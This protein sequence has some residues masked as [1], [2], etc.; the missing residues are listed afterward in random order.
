VHSRTLAEAFLD[1]LPS[2]ARTEAEATPEL[3]E[4]LRQVC[5]AAAQEWPE[6]LDDD[7][8]FLA[9]VASTLRE[10]EP[11]GAALGRIRAGDLC[12]AWACARGSRAALEQ[13][14][15]LYFGELRQVLRRHAH[16]GKD[17]EDL[18]QILRTRLFVGEGQT[19]PKILE[20]AGTGSLRGWMRAVFANLA[21]N[22]ATR[23]S[24]EI[25]V[26]DDLL[27]ALPDGGDTLEVSHVKEVYKDAFREA[28]VRATSELTSREKN[29]LRY[30]FADGLSIEQIASIYGVHRATAGQW[31][32]LA[33]ESL[34]ASMRRH[35]V[36]RLRLSPDDMQSALRLALSHIEITLARYLRVRP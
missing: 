19:G 29:V 1:A 26:A 31:L 24:R 12:L 7:A 34:A 23:E 21:L 18:E 11:V 15:S 3:P 33:R 16:L 30:R 36:E 2:R 17:V 35:L 5:A 20:Y 27:V 28:F 10:G 32:S 9:H 13:I 22:V 6:L 25:P 14:E 8:S 4:L